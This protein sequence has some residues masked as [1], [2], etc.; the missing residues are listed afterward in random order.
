MRGV[1]FIM[2]VS[3]LL[4]ACKKSPTEP[5]SQEN[6]LMPLKVGNTWNY[7]YSRVD[8]KTGDTLSSRMISVSI[9]GTVTIKGEEYYRFNDGS[10]ARNRNDGLIIADYNE[11]TGEL[12]DITFF[13]YPAKDGEVYDGIKVMTEQKVS[14]KAGTFFTYAYIFTASPYNS[15]IYIAPGV[16]I[17]K[18]VNFDAEGE[19]MELVSYEL[20]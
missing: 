16:G 15:T 4:S 2:A 5:S 20:K 6:V 18:T 7:K 8:P 10:V 3:L 11:R 1:I 14:V 17:V 12:G 9:V 13:K 19:G